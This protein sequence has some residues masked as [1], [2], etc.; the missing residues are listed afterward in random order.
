MRRPY[1][2]N[3]AAN[4]EA[5]SHLV[6][7]QEVDPYLVV[8][9]VAVPYRRADETRRAVVAFHGAVVP[10]RRAAV[11]LH[12]VDVPLHRFLR[13]AIAL[14]RR[15]GSSLNIRSQRAAPN[16]CFA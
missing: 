4:Q 7:N 10:C 15:T 13:T 5:P 8:V 16:A 6:Q 1:K 9:V 2:T 3:V 14:R 11:S 12:R